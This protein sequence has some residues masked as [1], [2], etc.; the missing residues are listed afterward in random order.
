MRLPS[1]REVPPELHEE[2][3]KL[4]LDLICYEIYSRH[5]SPEMEFLLDEHI[6]SCPTCRERV[7][8]FRRLMP[9]DACIVRNFG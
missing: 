4:L 6:G 7:L 5:L 2:C 1:E 8:G 3:Q 9:D